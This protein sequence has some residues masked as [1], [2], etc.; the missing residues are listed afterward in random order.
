MVTVPT[1]R[2]IRLHLTIAAAAGALLVAGVA[3]WGA[4]AVFSGA[5]IASGQLVVETN[6]KKVQHPT[7][8]VV[9]K[10]LVR[11]GSIVKAGDLLVRL[12]STQTRASL[13]IVTKSLDEF[14][15]R[16]ARLEEERD[17]TDNLTFPQILLAR[18]GIPEVARLM[19]SERRHFELRRD[20]RVGKK[21]Q[22]GERVIQLHEEIR[23]LTAQANAKV[24]EIELIRS[25]LEGVQSLWEKNLVSI[26]RLKTLDVM[27]RAFAASMV[28]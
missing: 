2:S 25:E 5:V 24:Q 28:R 22:L 8:G 12:D 7:G 17:G 15:A 26:S 23:G 19:Q 21:A 18:Q 11:D 6:V 27:R 20:A 16:N 1:R 4:T 13:G 14:Y 3:G 10:L 9:E